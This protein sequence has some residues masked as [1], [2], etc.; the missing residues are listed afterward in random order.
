[1]EK[2]QDDNE[3]N[4]EDEAL[5]H[6]VTKDIE[7]LP[8]DPGAPLV[9]E[10]PSD[11]PGKA[12]KRKTKPAAPSS[13]PSSTLPPVSAAQKKSDHPP[14]IDRRTDE[15]LKRGQMTIEARIDLHGMIR[16][17]ARAGLSRFLASSWHQGRRCVLVITGKGRDGAGVLRTEVPQWLREDDLAHFILRA[18]PAKPQHGGSGALYVLLRKKKDDR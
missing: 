18:Y 15:K 13:T 3:N 4:N 12:R 1:M 14:G 7:P 8:H 9:P 2:E 10:K 5:W 11:S 17:E 6:Y 16:T